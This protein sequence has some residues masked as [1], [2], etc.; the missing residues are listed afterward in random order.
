[1]IQVSGLKKNQK[2]DQV[3]W[4]M[5]VIPVTLEMEV[6]RSQSQAG[7]GRAS[8]RPYLKKKLAARGLRM[9]QCL[10]SNPVPQKKKKRKEGRK[11]DL[12]KLG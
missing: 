10:S 6:G 1:M 12:A 5:H 9:A 4:C 8:M 7:L 3:W 2:Q 11:E